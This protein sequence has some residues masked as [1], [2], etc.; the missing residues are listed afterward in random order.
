M[1]CS[2]KIYEKKQ[3]ITAGSMRDASTGGNGFHELCNN[4]GKYGHVYKYCKIPITSFGV[5]LFRYHQGERQYLMIRR[6]DTLGYIDFMRG[7]YNGNDEFYIINMIK[8]MTEEERTNL[9]TKSF[10][11]LWGN[12]WNIHENESVEISKQYKAEECG[13]R[14]KFHLL[15]ESGA[16][17]TMVK[18]AG[19][20]PIWSEPEWGFPKGRRNYQEKDYECALREMKEE[21]G[22]S[23][24][25]M[26]NIKNILPFEEIF[27][28]S[29]YKSYK[30]KYYLVYL[31]DTKTN[32]KDSLTNFDHGEVSAM[33]WKNYQE[34]IGCIRPYNIEKLRMLQRVENTLSKYMIL[35]EL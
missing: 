29:N 5:I 18:K 22:F 19:E 33:E 21:T 23:A 12:L 24:E 10:E 1:Y 26:N 14:K 27:T 15:K 9:L 32:M 20:D 31:E 25:W 7:K 3:S 28:G 2:N 16:L 11:F 4:C 8:Q 35:Y 34:C 30:H 6:K 17:E 13:S